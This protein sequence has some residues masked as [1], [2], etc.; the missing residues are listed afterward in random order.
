M[1][2]GERQG[3][4]PLLIPPHDAPATSFIHRIILEHFSRL[5][6]PGWRQTLISL[7]VVALGVMS[8]QALKR[9]DRDL[10]I[11]YTDYTVAATDLAHVLAD[12][13]RYR[14]VL[15]GAMEASSKKEFER[16]TRSL[17]HQ[18]QTIEQTVDRFASVIMRAQDRSVE[19]PELQEV[20]DGLAAYFAAAAKTM[21]LMDERW[22]ATT[23]AE[24]AIRQ[25][26]VEHHVAETAGPKLVQV[27]L[28]ID[29][30]LEAVALVGKDL[31]DEGSTMIRVISMTLI[32]GSLLLAGINLLAGATRAA[33]SGR[34]VAGVEYPGP[35]SGG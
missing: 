28:A 2:S 13:M 5:N 18:R 32:I 21:A 23:P 27:T 35:R 33:R 24:A 11:M 22:R 20:R 10:R 16:V 19:P 26:R 7:L 34:V 29:R 15:I 9:V 14:N 17:P 6:P 25:G 3:S 4:P 1:R 8:A 30:L 12:I 31:R